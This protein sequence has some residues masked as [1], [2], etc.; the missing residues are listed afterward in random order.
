MLMRIGELAER[1]GVSHRTIH[2]YEGLGLLQPAEREGVGY[3]Y[4]DE[5]S[6]RR[7]N[8]IGA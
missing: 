1:A 6:L 8:K 3:R 4:Y 5:T 7:I 2:Y